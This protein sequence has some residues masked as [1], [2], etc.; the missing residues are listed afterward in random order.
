M[1]ILHRSDAL[2]LFFPA[3]FLNVK[4]LVISGS[5]SSMASYLLDQDQWGFAR[6]EGEPDSGA[7]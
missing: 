7:T 6:R 4:A 5:L 2:P 1:Q 3:N